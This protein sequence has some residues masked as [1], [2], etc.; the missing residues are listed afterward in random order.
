MNFGQR[1]LPAAPPNRSALR[2]NEGKTISSPT[3]RHSG[4]V[5][6]FFGASNRL[7]TGFE[8]I[9]KKLETDWKARPL[10][11]SRLPS[12]GGIDRFEE[13]LHWF[14]SAA[15]LIYLLFEMVTL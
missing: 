2:V 6:E 14:L 15:A 5:M 9:G 3:R 7:P 8:G 1:E 4:C 13:S 10:P 11:A 12:L